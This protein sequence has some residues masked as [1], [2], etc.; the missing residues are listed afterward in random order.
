MSLPAEPPGAVSYGLEE[1]LELLAALED[2]RDALTESD[3]LAV[4]AQLE[5]Q[6]AR[7]SLKLGFG[8]SP[9]GEDG[10]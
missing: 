8:Q 2:A 3:H 9:G 7:L 5:H 1:A 4:L 6:V 10:S